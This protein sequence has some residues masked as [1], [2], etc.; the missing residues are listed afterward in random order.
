MRFEGKKN[1]LI[2]KVPLKPDT[3]YRLGFFLKMENVKLLPGIRV[4]NG[5]FY[6]RV[7]EGGKAHYFPKFAYYGSMPW[8][9]LEH[10]WR[11]GAKVGRSYSPYIHFTL[12]NVTGKAWVDHVEL[13][14][15]ADK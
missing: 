6:L 8:L 3:W 2:H 14:E 11:T 1:A 13:T 15:I 7:D 4:T 5:G 9:Y 12:R 10:T